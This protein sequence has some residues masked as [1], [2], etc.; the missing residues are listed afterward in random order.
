[1]T[2]SMLLGSAALAFMLAVL[3]LNM[4]RPRQAAAVVGLGA[5]LLVGAVNARVGDSV[6][7]CGSLGNRVGL[8]APPIGMDSLDCQRAVLEI[9]VSWLRTGRV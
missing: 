5:V 4:A 8:G 1:M 6:T 3:L 9:Y 2:G 7:P